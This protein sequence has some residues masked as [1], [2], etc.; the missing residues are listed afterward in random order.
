MGIKISCLSVR[1]EQV[2]PQSEYLQEAQGKHAVFLDV[3]RH[4][5]SDSVFGFAHLL[6]VPRGRSYRGKLKKTFSFSV[7]AH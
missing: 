2:T 4:D 5:A 3:S 7:S 1:V 6:R